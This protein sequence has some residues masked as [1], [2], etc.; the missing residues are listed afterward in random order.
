VT[1][2]KKQLGD[3][4]AAF[5]M[6]KRI[7]LLNKERKIVKLYENI[8]NDSALL[9]MMSLTLIKRGAE[10]VLNHKKY[11]SLKDQGNRILKYIREETCAR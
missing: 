4:P 5:F 6:E 10:I 7:S 8:E 3:D 1:I 11:F 2:R 9:K